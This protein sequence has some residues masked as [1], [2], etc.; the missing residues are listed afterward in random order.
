MSGLSKLANTPALIH[1]VLAGRPL[2]LAPFVRIANAEADLIQDIEICTQLGSLGQ[3]FA[4]PSVLYK[5]TALTQSPNPTTA[6]PKHPRP[7]PEKSDDSELVKKQKKA[8]KEG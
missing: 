2:D 1:Q 7:S 6:S 3:I 5:K 4:E 8:K